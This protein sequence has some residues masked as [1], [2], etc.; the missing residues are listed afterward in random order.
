VKRTLRLTVLAAVVAT[1]LVALPSARASQGAP[2][3][4]ELVR[5]YVASFQGYDVPAG[6]RTGTAGGAAAHRWFADRL[7]DLGLRARTQ[8][9]EVPV[10]RTRTASLTIGD[11]KPNVFPL[12]YSGVTSNQGV[13]APLVDVG[14]GTAAEFAATDVAGKIAVIH[15]PMGAAKP[16][17]LDSGVTGATAG[18]ALALVAA[19]DGPGN[20]IPPPNTPYRAEPGPLPVLLLGWEDGEALRGRTGTTATFVLD[21]EIVDRTIDNTYAVVPGTGPGVVVVGTPLNGWFNVASERGSGIAVLLETAR[22]TVSRGH[23]PAQTVIFAG[24]GGHEIEGGG[25]ARFFA[26][27]TDG[28]VTAYVH[29]G[30]T[31]AGRTLVETPTGVVALDVN[32]PRRAIYVSENPLLVGL[33]AQSFGPQLTGQAIRPSPGGV[34]NP[35]EQADAYALRIPNVAISGNSL[36]FHTTGDTP[37]VTTSQALLRPMSDA[38]D[39]LLQSLVRTDPAT[40]RSANGAADQLAKPP[41]EPDACPAPIR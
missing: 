21:A 9:F 11:S 40:L 1:T 39:Q 38:Y 22:R 41:A 34:G 19:I 36:Y 17:T 10:F 5:S 31:I 6:P 3:E 25:L 37:D 24:F 4:L 15:S 27:F 13:T 33:V 18:G 16:Q 2:T 14:A 8:R 23:A 12:H 35:G 29:L 26:C 30:A 28:Q 32:E 7:A 20:L